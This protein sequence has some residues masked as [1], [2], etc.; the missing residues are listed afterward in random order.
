MWTHAAFDEG[1]GKDVLLTRYVFSVERYATES[2]AERLD[3]QQE[4]MQIVALEGIE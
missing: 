1:I 4:V 3:I 2:A